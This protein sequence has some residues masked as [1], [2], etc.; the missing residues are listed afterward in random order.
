M[1]QD[2][3]DIKGIDWVMEK[4]RSG[5]SAFSGFVSLFLKRYNN[6]DKLTLKMLRKR[7]K[8]N[9]ARLFYFYYF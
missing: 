4:Y 5:H 6:S 2:F 8:N 7:V 1:L 3:F 9:N